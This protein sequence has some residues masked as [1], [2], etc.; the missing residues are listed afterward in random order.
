MASGRCAIVQ[1]MQASSVWILGLRNLW[2]DLR[3]GELRLIIVAVLLA[4]AALSSVGFFA[5][6]LQAGLQRDAR[7][8]LGGDV[9]VV[10][11]NPAPTVFVQQARQ[12]GLQSVATASFPTMARAAQEQGGASRLVALKSVEPGYPLRGVLHL[13]QGPGQPDLE[14]RAIPENGHA[15]VDAPL[16]EALGLKLGDRLLLGDASFLISHIIAIEPDRGAGFMSFA[17]RVM[18]NSADLAATRL[19]Q[20]ASRIT[21]RLAVAAQADAGRGAQRAAQDYLGWAQEL[22]KSLHG[23]RVESLESGRPEMRQTLDRAE[24]F[25]SLVA[26]LSALLSA[27]AV[28]LAARAFANSH[29]DAS[30]MLRVLGQS[31]RRIALAYVVEF[32]SI[33]LAASVAGVLLGWAV[34]HVFVWLLAGLV[35]SALPAAS[36]WP[37]LFGMGMGLTLLLAFGL[38][39]VLQLAQVPPLRVMRRDLG[40]LKPASWLVLGVGVTGF[41][42]LLMVAS[43]D[44]KLGLIAVGG[45]AVAVLL[46]AGLAWLAV[47]LLRQVV[48]ESTAPRWLVMATRQVSAKPVYAVVQVSSLAVGLLALVL[49]VLLRTDLIASWRKATPA[50]AP[51]RFVINVQPDQAQDFQA[52]LKK[53]GVHSYDWY[54]MIRGRLI[55]V[56]GKAVSPDDYEEDRAKRL[57]DREFNIS[58]AETMPDHNQIVGGR[59]QAGEQG[60]I[61]MEEGIAK[62]LGLKLGD[63]LRF[64]IGGEESEA[65]ITSLRKVDWSSMRANFFVIYPVQHL[66]NVAVTYLA[67]YRA[68]DVKGFDNALVNEFPNI[69]NVDLSS[70]L[71][72]VQQVMDQVIRAVEFLFGFTLV[73]GL[74]VL[75]ASVTGTR[76]ERAREYAIMRAVGARSGLLQQVQSAEL[77]GVG[78]MAGFLASCVALAVGWALARWVFDFEWNVLWWVPLVGA[79]AGAL[80]AWLAG[81]WALREVVSRPVMITLRQAAE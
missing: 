18:I 52:A 35:E 79:L 21:Y 24:K 71:A 68:P 31:Q 55:A 46:F 59:W 34:H 5:D 61:S 67:A 42:A 38:P 33:A 10:S 22:A 45:F 69:T 80:L 4:V 75:F 48:N 7:Q 51:D 3:A 65:R 43:R 12:Q 64:D 8:L 29:L 2:R 19:V 28:A 30:A 49:L 41:A 56:N 6:R 50:N 20:P 26:L 15:W 23:V 60:A 17:P 70:T 36:L 25:L 63:T 27:V 57:V 62:T 66:E 39:P 81:W 14:V 77:A 76:E 40:A 11:D 1:T 16:L 44:I 73:A 9:V 54:P 37:A 78:L 13:N 74:V 58:N 72:Q 32:V 47:K 53:A